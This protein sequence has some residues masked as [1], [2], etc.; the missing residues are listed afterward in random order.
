MHE[1]RYMISDAS[2]RVDVEQ[3]TL[4]YW[5]EELSLHIPRN[6]MGHR[7]YRDEDIEMLKAIKILKDQGYQ[8]RAIKML[9]PEIQKL[10]NLN[11]EDLLKIKQE[12]DKQYIDAIAGMDNEGNGTFSSDITNPDN[13]VSSKANSS[14]DTGG[15]NTSK[16]EIYPM[17]NTQIKEK[18]ADVIL[19]K[20]ME[21]MDQF[22]TIMSNLIT[23]ALTDNNEVLAE[24]V[25]E[26]VS[27]NVIKEMD[28]LL[29]IKEEREEERYKQFDRML[30][31]IQSGR[32]EVA[33]SRF[34]KKKRRK[35]MFQKK[36]D[37]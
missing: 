10:K 19:N 11:Q 4:R 7:Y 14:P 34:D 35:K 36:S 27:T 30:R 18:Q 17:E 25:S 21:K 16:E 6:E 8:L 12:W 5:E 33:A 31:E 28:Y 3:H 1:T 9:L 15:E 32:S 20:P 22:K 29:R 26:A 24:V 37:L 13:V 2:K 23:D